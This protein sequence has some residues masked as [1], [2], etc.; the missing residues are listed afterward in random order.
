MRK[1][2]FTYFLESERSMLSFF[3]LTGRAGSLLQIGLLHSG[4]PEE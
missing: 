4:S 3:D 1:A 2:L